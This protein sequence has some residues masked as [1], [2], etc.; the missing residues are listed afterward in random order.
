MTDTGMICEFDVDMEMRDGVV[1]RANVF[2]PDK[3]GT[4][5]GILLR[6]PYCKPIKGYPTAMFL[7]VS[8][9][10][11]L[12]WFMIFCHLITISK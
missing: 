6:T 3:K 1:L 7:N 10:L 12:F 11:P 8:F 5:P 9:F 4:Y 2:R